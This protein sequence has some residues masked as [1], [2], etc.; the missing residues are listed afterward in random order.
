MST[1]NAFGM[2]RRVLVTRPQPAAGGTARRLAELGFDPIVLPLTEISALSFDPLPDVAA[3]DAV[4]VTSAN[5]LRHADPTLLAPFLD[6][7]CFAVGEET[8]SA[9]ARAGFSSVVAGPGDAVGLARIVTDSLSSGVQLLYLCGRM[10]LSNVEDLLREKG[11]HVVVVETYDAPEIAYPAGELM[12]RLGSEPLDAALLYS[13]RA[14]TAIGR[15]VSLPEIEPLFAETLFLCISERV[16]A[17]FRGVPQ[18][19]VFVA[20]TPEEAGLLALLVQHC[21]NGA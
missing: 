14:A 7:P 18:A 12:V 1:S 16:A 4:V 20:R 5:A 11:M 21:G 17:A 3:T 10:R 15:L 2:S 9:A 19:R 13:S 8:A 6:M